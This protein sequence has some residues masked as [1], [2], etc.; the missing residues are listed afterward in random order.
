MFRSGSNISQAVNLFGKSDL[1]QNKLLLKLSEFKCKVGDLWEVRNSLP[2]LLTSKQIQ[3]L[4]GPVIWCGL[5]FQSKEMM[6]CRLKFLYCF[7]PVDDFREKKH[8]SS[9]MWYGR[10]LCPAL[11]RVFMCLLQPQS[12]CKAPLIRALFWKNR[13]CSV[14][15]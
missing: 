5:I 9:S 13:F 6:L 8:S 1:Q 3:T 14:F 12:G 10:L 15:P 7:Q 11:Y 2:L 4:G